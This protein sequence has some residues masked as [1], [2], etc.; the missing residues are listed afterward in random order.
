MDKPVSRAVLESGLIKGDWIEQLRRWGLLTTEAEV[1]P[2]TEPEEV[3]ARIQ[4]VLESSDVVEI[5]DTDLDIIQ[6][7][8]SN[9]EKGKLHVPS[10]EDEMKT[11]PIP[12]EFCR[13]AMGEYVIPWTTESIRDLMLDEYTYLKPKGAPRVRFQEVRELL[14]DAKKAFMVCSPVED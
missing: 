11:V 10:P 5:R 4:Q 9:R 1:R 6:R 3:A 14:Y 7:Y 8:L 2:F 13:S 12:V